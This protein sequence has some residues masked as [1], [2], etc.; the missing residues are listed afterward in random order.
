MKGLNHTSETKDKISVTLKNKP[1]YLVYSKEEKN[2][3]LEQHKEHLNDIRIQ[4][5]NPEIIEKMAKTRRGMILP[6]P[7]RT[8]LRLARLKAQ[9]GRKYTKEQIEKRNNTRHRNG[10]YIPS[11]ATK[12]KISLSCKGKN[13]G[14]RRFDVTIKHIKDCIPKY[15]PLITDPDIISNLVKARLDYINSTDKPDR[16]DKWIKNIIL[17]LGPEEL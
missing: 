3:L 14:N 16:M 7:H 1:Y 11:E 8:N 6:E 17:E 13:I 9:I 5:Y 10:N 15:F 2:L 4:I 12:L